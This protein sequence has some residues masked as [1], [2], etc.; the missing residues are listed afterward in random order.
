MVNHYLTAKTRTIFSLVESSLRVR[1]YAWNG[2]YMVA[3]KSKP[4]PNHQ[5]NR[6]K[7]Y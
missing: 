5:K 3:Q 7:L 2:K 6:I 4:L 1:Y